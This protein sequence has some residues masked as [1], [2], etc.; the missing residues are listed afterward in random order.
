M[1]VV[2]LSRV[3]PKMPEAELISHTKKTSVA[4]STQLYVKIAFSDLFLN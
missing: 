1:K 4:L 3:L 2:P